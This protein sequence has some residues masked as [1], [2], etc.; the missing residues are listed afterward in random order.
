MYDSLNRKHFQSRYKLHLT[1]SPT[2][3]RIKNRIAKQMITVRGRRTTRV[4][5]ALLFHKNT[6]DTYSYFYERPVVC[7]T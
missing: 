5:A 2:L 6:I 1:E 4:K 3:K 7:Q